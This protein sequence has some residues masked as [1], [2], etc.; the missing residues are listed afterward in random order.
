MTV[1]QR[2]ALVV[3]ALR[4]MRQAPDTRA[5]KRE[6]TAGNPYI[7]RLLASRGLIYDGAVHRVEERDVSA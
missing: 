3:R 4:A 5:I 7:E 2:P 6:A 1:N